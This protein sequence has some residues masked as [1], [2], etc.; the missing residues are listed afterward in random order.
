MCN[1]KKKSYMCPKTW[2]N[3]TTRK[4]TKQ[5]K[6]QR[7]GRNEVDGTTQ[8]DEKKN[9]KERKIENVSFGNLCRNEPSSY[10]S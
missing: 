7:M 2:A 3:K 4:K 6:L 10:L 1:Q 8:C 5:M 9:Q